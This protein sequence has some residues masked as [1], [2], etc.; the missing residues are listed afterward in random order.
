MLQH[1][2]LDISFPLHCFT[3][4]LE[5]M[6]YYDRPVFLTQLLYF[7][8]TSLNTCSNLYINYKIY[9]Q[10]KFNSYCLDFI[11]EPSVNESP[12]VTF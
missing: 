9:K 10:E 2:I 4:A 8:K 1:T 7:L 5:D 12:T 3:V 6:S 11:L